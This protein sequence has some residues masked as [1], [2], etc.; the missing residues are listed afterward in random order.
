MLEPF[1]PYLSPS[2]RVKF[3][4]EAWEFEGARALR[5]QVFCREQGLFDADDRDA[6]DDYATTIVAVSLLAGEPDEVVGSVRIHPEAP[7]V[8]WGS[9]LAVAQRFR[10]VAGLGAGLIRLAVGSARG[11]GCRAFYAHV[12]AQN[13]PLF[14]R[15]HWEPLQ[16]IELR[17]WPHWLMRADLGQY[18]V[19]AA[20]ELGVPLC[21]RAA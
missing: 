5:Q 8:W 3:A 11:L 21:A 20:P 4:T 19:I 6:V 9:R 14:E 2:Y 1:H 10:K 12:Q 16:E 13:R 17:G 15:L 18:P 7:G